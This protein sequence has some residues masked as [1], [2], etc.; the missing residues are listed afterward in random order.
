[1]TTTTL[2]IFELHQSKLIGLAYRITGSIAE[3]EDITQETFLKWAATDQKK[4][5]APYSWLMKVATRMSLDH[6]KSARVQRESYIGPWLP[7]PFIT[8]YKTPEAEHE[9]DESIT[10][11][12]LVLLEQLAPG[13]RAVF[14]L[15]DL[16]HFNFDEIG[17]ILDKSGTSCRKLASRARAK[18]TRDKIQ[19]S[20]NKSVHKEIIAAFFNAVKK[21]DVNNLTS[22]LKDDVI[23]HVDDGGKAKAALKILKGQQT[24]ATF[25]VNVVTPD[26]SGMNSE[27]ITNTYL[28]FNGS[29]GFVIREN[30]KPVSAFNFEIKNHKIKKI[31]VLRNPDKLKF[32]NNK[33]L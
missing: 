28:W 19:E 9:L 16:F 24:I 20:S 13:E 6:L 23:I 21:G 32:F 1:M 30:S 17:E 12:L 2:D 22:L 5:Q 3:A 26:F 14:I 31:H 25:L 29:P 4:I 15:H 8:D 33:D 27:E 10:M 7:E 18:I 11:A